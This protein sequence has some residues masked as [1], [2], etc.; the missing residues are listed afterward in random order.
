MRLG[1]VPN[2]YLRMG[3]VGCGVD[4]TGGGGS[5]GGDGGS[6]EEI[7][8]RALPP[9]MQTAAGGVGVPPGAAPFHPPPVAYRQSGGHHPLPANV[10]GPPPPPPASG[11]SKRCYWCHLCKREFPFPSKLNEHMRT[12]TGE[13][14]FACPLCPFRTSLKWNLK[15]HMLRH[16]D[17]LGV[18][19]PQT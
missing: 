4:V 7:L 17:S 19:R 16:Q 15:S 12:H 2:V 8:M 9:G 10:G 18:S 3:A 13:K 6:L 11:P 14:P 5:E 1:E